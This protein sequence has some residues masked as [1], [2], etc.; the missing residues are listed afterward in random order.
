MPT[1]KPNKG[2]RAT[3][4]AMASIAPSQQLGSRLLQLPRELRHEVFELFFMSTGFSLGEQPMDRI[5]VERIVTATSN[6]LALLRTCQQVFQ[7]TRHLWIS[8]ALFGFE[9][10]KALLDILADL[11]SATVASIRHIRIHGAHLTLKSLH[12]KEYELYQI[13]TVLK[14]L[15]HL[16][17]DTLTVRKSSVK[18]GGAVLTLYRGV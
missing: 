16:R 7:E 17:L 9:T 11:P 1:S 5:G 2:Q 12:S 18:K 10:T 13:G 14:L 3:K 15:H 4:R 8:N 6:G